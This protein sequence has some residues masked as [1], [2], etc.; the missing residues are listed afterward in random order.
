MH[1]AYSNITMDMYSAQ[2]KL[3]N[4][5]AFECLYQ[6]YSDQIITVSIDNIPE[7][8]VISRDSSLI[9]IEFCTL[10]VNVL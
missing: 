3:S 1:I 7:Q 10:N 9:S 8:L 5:S 4:M 6:F 2:E